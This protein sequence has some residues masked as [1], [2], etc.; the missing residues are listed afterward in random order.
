MLSERQEQIIEESI[1][2][3]AEKGIQGFTIKNLSKAIGISE[4]GIYRHFENK[5][6]ILLTILDQFLDMAQMLSGLVENNKLSAVQ[7]ISFMFNKMVERFE[8]TPLLVSV[9][10]SEEIFKNEEVLK[11]KIIKIL[12]TNEDTLEAIIR[13]GQKNNEIRTD[14]DEKVL[15][16]MVMGS[17]RL[18]VKRWDLNEHK[19]DLSKEGKLLLNSIEAVLSV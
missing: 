7:K 13:T 2:L 19:F 4:P 8:E 3:I 16:L 11:R 9:I 15:A 18:L 17:L 10:F 6:K 1:N 14:S 12:N 5:T